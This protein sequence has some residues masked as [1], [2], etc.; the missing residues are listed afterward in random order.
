MNESR[1]AIDRR[2]INDHIG[3]DDHDRHS[4]VVENAVGCRAEQTR[5]NAAAPTAPDDEEIAVANG[6][7]QGRHWTVFDQRAGDGDATSLPRRFDRACEVQSASIPVSS[8][9]WVEPVSVG[10]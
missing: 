2:E 6:F 8:R 3:A 5:P 9:P 4:A 1:I 10:G 7:E